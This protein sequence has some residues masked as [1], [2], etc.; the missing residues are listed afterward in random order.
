MAATLANG[1]VNPLTG[2][3]VLAAGDRP[4][5]PE[6]HG[7]VRH[8]RRA[9]ASGCTRS[10]SRRRAA[11]RAGILAVVPGQLGIGVFSPP[12]DAQGNSV[13]GVAVCRDLVR[14]LDLHLLGRGP[15]RRRR[16]APGTR[17]RGS[18]SKRAGRRR[19]ATV[20][21]RGGWQAEVASSR[22]T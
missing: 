12:L 4:R 15:A 10:A 20:L 7:H 18:R 9:P 11:S 19:S 21:A 6:R 13:R 17:S 2:E 5:R 8:V 22:A 1:G 14:E 16:C 3:R